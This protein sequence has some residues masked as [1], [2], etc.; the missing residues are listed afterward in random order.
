MKYALE[1]LRLIAHELAEKKDYSGAVDH[2]LQ[3]KKGAKV[4]PWDVAFYLPYYEILEKSSLKDV[5]PL[6]PSLNKGIIEALSICAIHLDENPRSLLP[7][8]RIH[9]TGKK[10][11]EDLLDRSHRELSDYVETYKI[12]KKQRIS[13]EKDYIFQLETILSIS[14]TYINGMGSLV[15]YVPINVTLMW[16]FFKLNDRILCHLIPYEKGEIREKWEKKQAELIEIIQLQDS[17][18]LPSV[19]V[20]SVFPKELDKWWKLGKF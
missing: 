10:L 11:V 7:F 4:Y 1:E 17:S 12:S 8:Q 14:E 15:E 2:L 16:N 19:L 6:V 20:D 13:L 3:V 18:Y 5:F 9:D